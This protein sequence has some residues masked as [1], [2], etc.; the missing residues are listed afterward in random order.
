MWF[1]NLQI[2]RLPQPW[3]ISTSELEDK[4]AKHRFQPCGTQDPHSEGWVAPVDWDERL[5]YNIGGQWLIALGREE[6]LLPASVVRQEVNER[7]QVHAETQGF[8][9][10]R[11]QVQSI[12]E[13]VIQEFLP[14]AFTRRSRMYAWI[15]PVNGWLVMDA[16]S[17][18]RAERLLE[19][20]HDAVVPLPVRLLRTE[21]S[22]AAV[23]TQWLLAGEASEGFTLDCECELRAVNE[24]KSTVRYLRHPLEAPEIRAHLEA[25]K[26][27]VRLGLVLQDRVAATLTDK[28]ELKKLA[29]LDVVRESL[30]SL[31]ESDAAAVFDA[32]F[33]LMTAEL[34]TLLA[35]L[36]AALGGEAKA[37]P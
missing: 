9:P 2:Y 29:F 13:E 34:Q 16:S 30:E 14:R 12:K 6:R 17:P 26:Q 7:V 5:V 37:R 25:G 19:A 3:T 11:K 31:D 22:P 4:L 10:G 32:E 1:K 27:P 36:L 18:T 15:D 35:A 21:R 23:M 8:R 33:A 20:L 28:G 24:E